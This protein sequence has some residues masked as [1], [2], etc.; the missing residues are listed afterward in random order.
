MN[1]DELS[2]EIK[3]TTEWT[4]SPVIHPSILTLLEAH[5]KTLLIVQEY[6]LL[7]NKPKNK[8]PFR[9]HIESVWT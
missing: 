5:L 6:R 9:E 8:S 3:R 4:L 1:D 7:T 2:N